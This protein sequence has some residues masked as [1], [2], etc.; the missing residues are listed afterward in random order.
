MLHILEISIIKETIKELYQKYRD[1]LEEHRNDL[2]A[3]LMKTR[4]GCFYQDEINKYDWSLTP[5]TG[6]T[7]RK[8]EYFILLTA[9]IP[10]LSQ[11]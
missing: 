1:R 8:K 9:K 11:D 5:Q 6:K 2:A 3:N 7:T 10:H 4:V